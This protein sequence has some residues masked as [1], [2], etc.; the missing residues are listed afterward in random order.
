MWL[1][2]IIGAL[3]V[4]APALALSAAGL[5]VQDFQSL[6]DLTV[7]GLARKEALLSLGSHMLELVVN[8]NLDGC[9]LDTV[10]SYVGVIYMA[11]MVAANLGIGKDVLHQSTIIVLSKVLHIWENEIVEDQECASIS[12]VVND[13]S[14]CYPLMFNPS[15]VIQL[16]R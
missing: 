14:V 13:L 8:I 6:T 7:Y 11:F 3:A 1:Q 15:V 4:E 9:P 5:Q 12:K 10:V 16:T 2:G